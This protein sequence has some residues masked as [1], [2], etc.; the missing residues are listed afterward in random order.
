MEPVVRL[1]DICNK[2]LGSEVRSNQKRHRE[3]QE[4]KDKLFS[5]ISKR[6]SRNRKKSEEFLEVV[7]QDEKLMDNLASKVSDRINMN[8]EIFLG[9]P[10]KEGW[11]RGIMWRFPVNPNPTNPA[12]EQYIKEQQQN[13]M[14]QNLIKK[15]MEDQ[16]LKEERDRD[17]KMAEILEQNKVISEDMDKIKKKLKIR[18]K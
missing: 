14:V 16:R 8:F 4:E 17:K 18:K 6:K 9:K 13:G 1:C 2:P 11:Q 10:N 7:N 3:C 15:S 12:L 5:R